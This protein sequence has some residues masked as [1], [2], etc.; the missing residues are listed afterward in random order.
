VR[1]L[2]DMSRLDVDNVLTLREPCDLSDI[3]AGVLE[4]LRPIL[5]SRPLHARFPTEPLLLECDQNQMETVIVNLVENAVKY[6]PPDSALHLTGSSV[7]GSIVFSLRDEGPGVAPGEKAR[8]FD[9]FYRVGTRYARG[10][11]GLGLAICK[12]IVEAHGGTIRVDDAL[13]GGAV[14]SLVLPVAKGSDDGD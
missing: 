2:L 1:N 13:E 11:T 12:T 14:F 6:S 7:G 10:G 9:K 3:V 5:R 4:R 8:I